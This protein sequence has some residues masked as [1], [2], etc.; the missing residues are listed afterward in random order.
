MNPKTKTKTETPQ[1][2]SL[3][4]P[5]HITGYPTLQRLDGRLTLRQARALRAIFDGLQRDGAEV[6]LTGRYLVR[7][8]IDAIRWILDRVAESLPETG[9]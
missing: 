4:I 2:V 9:N 8:H 6:Q 1:G 3:H 7:N 5:T